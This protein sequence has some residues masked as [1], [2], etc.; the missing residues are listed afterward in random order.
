MQSQGQQT[1]HATGAAAVR[2]RRFWMRASLMLVLLVLVGV[3]VVVRR[4]FFT[5][6]S[7]RPGLPLIELPAAASNND[8]LVVLLSGDGGWADWSRDAAGLRCWGCAGYGSGLAERPC[9]A[10]PWWQKQS[11]QNFLRAGADC[12]RTCSID[13]A[14]RVSRL[15]PFTHTTHKG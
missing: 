1:S 14:H 7:S 10:A 9:A 12:P 2:K 5:A 6:P 15:H 4:E 11:W 13:H 8:V 3:S